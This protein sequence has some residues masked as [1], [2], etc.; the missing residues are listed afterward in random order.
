MAGITAKPSLEKGGLAGSINYAPS[1]A[2]TRSTALGMLNHENV[3]GIV[4]GVTDDAN[5]FWLGESNAT[6][7]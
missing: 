7:D 4:G 5:G 1:P 3:P 2:K 6:R